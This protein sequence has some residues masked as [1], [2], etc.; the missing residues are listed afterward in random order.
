MGHPRSGAARTPDLQV[1]V[2]TEM[3]VP[4]AGADSL[5]DGAQ[6]AMAGVMA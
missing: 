2:F 4:A 3:G 6:D 5:G 1:E